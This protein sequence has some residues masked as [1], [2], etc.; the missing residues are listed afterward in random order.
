MEEENNVWECF[1]PGVGS[2]VEALTGG[3]GGGCFVPPTL[4]GDLGQRICVEVV[5]EGLSPIETESRPESPA[6]RAASAAN[7]VGYG[8][9]MVSPTV[10]GARVFLANHP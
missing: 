10:L 3:T 9:V 2:K 4:R 5:V 8:V 7:V 6:K 1:L